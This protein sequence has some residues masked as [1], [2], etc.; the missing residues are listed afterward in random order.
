MTALTFTQQDMHGQILNIVREMY[1][2][3][4]KPDYIVGIA[5]DGIVPAVMLGKYLEIPLNTLHV[6]VK[7]NDGCETN[8]WMAEDA[9]GIDC[10]LKQILVLNNVNYSGATF[11]WI[12]RDWNSSIGDD[13][14]DSIWHN[15]VKFAALVHN[16]YSILQSDFAGVTVSLDPIDRYTFEFPI[17]NWWK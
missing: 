1:Q 4:F 7:S 8:L 2:T 16:E 11:D 10:P 3:G 6:E 5:P 14:R 17:N 15:N 13:Q 9:A 12:K